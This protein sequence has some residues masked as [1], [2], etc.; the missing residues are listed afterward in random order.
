M[1][2]PSKWDKVIFPSDWIASLTF[3]DPRS[4][5]LQTFVVNTQP[6]VMR[7]LMKLQEE[8]QEAVVTAI[9]D[10]HSANVS[11]CVSQ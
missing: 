10:S 2:P 7:V 6:K 5:W 1:T 4:V 9:R 3:L 8:L 11:A